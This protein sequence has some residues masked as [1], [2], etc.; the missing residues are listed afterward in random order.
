[1]DTHRIDPVALISG[2]FFGLAGLAV[3]AN[4]QWDDV[5]VTAFTAAGV[6]VIGLLLLGLVVA[7]YVRDASEPESVDAT[8]IRD[9]PVALHDEAVQEEAAHES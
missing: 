3:F 6:M 8:I 2:L 4:Q 9:D 5:D 7:R 1:M